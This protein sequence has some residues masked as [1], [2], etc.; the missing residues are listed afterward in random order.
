MS[1]ELPHWFN[2]V[3]L[4]TLDKRF[5]MFLQQSCVAF[6]FLFYLF[7]FWYSYFVCRFNICIAIIKNGIFVF[8]GYD[9]RY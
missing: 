6:L 8:H 3:A 2:E 7:V 5:V 9:I 1:K 4:N